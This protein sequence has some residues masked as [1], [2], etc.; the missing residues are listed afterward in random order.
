[1]QITKQNFK[2]SFSFIASK[3]K[4]ASFITMDF[5][6]TGINSNSKLRN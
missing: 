6:M 1:M 4:E 3:V 5:E 2:E